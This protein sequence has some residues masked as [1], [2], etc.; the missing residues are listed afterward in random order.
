MRFDDMR[1]VGALRL[2][3]PPAG[4]VAR[5][6]DRALRAAAQ[7]PDHSEAGRA[8]AAD[9]LR[10]RG[11][12]MDRWDAS[13][14]GFLT[15]RDLAR[16]DALFFG[17]GAQLRRAFGLAGLLSLLGLFAQLGVDSV[18]GRDIGGEALRTVLAIVAV[19]GGGAW[20][21]ASLF[22]RRPARV[23]VI[24]PARHLGAP[25]RRFIRRELRA[26]G[27][28]IM[29]AAA[30]GDSAVRSASAYRAMAARLRQRTAFNLR[31]L[32]SDREGL[33][34]SADEAW[35]TLILG[36]LAS[37]SDVVVVDL[38]DG[39]SWAWSRLQQLGAL[40]RAVFVADWG[41]HAGAAMALRALESEA[42]CFAYAPDGEVQRRS[43]FRAQMLKAMR[44]ALG[45]SA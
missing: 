37:S 12:S 1:T 16:G 18:G 43:A 21:A 10:A 40:R 20:L 2:Q 30:T 39:G 19:G 8:A 24:A 4:A 17:A 3:E 29:L 11:L 14:P 23:S 7:N 25:L 41:K 38:S 45:A 27:H 33:S 9:V 5:M 44:A 22:R 13:A 26:Y 32:L 35:R 31:M 28:V 15:P 36:L 42:P 34:V 6:S